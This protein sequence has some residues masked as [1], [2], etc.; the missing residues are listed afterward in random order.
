MENKT[1]SIRQQLLEGEI[2]VIIS[3]K[4]LNQIKYL[5]TRISEVEWSGVLFYST[6]GDINRVDDFSVILEY[7][8]LMDKGT[9]G[10]TDYELGEELIGFGM[11]NPESLQWKIGHIHSHNSMPT[12]FSGTDMSEL[13]DN[14]ELHNY[15]LSII[16]NNRLDITGKIAF[17]GKAENN[18][19]YSC[20]TGAGL[21]YKI[22]LVDKEEI[23]FIYDC[24]IIVDE[25]VDEVFANRA[26]KIIIDATKKEAL[27]KKTNIVPYQ[28]TTKNPFD[29]THQAMNN[30]YW[31]ND[32]IIDNVDELDESW[33]IDFPSFWIC[34][35]AL[36]S[37]TLTIHEALRSIQHDIKV[38]GVSVYTANLI[39]HSTELYT[40]FFEGLEDISITDAYN[41]VYEVLDE[42]GVDFPFTK[43]MKSALAFF[44]E[45]LEKI[46]TNG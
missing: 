27:K 41:T 17:R 24:D 36:G 3:E 8:Y 30:Y 10:A 18:V 13:N 11:D 31:E 22:K 14:S 33:M 7:I 25:L 26:T 12:F 42:S 19:H 20:K 1:K 38:E 5:T 32:E 28:G 9:G 15:Y 39:D 44:L 23:M 43:D 34:F 35:G 40:K 46:K 2:P 16:V 21:G 6:V 4:V 45:E 29:R 37:E